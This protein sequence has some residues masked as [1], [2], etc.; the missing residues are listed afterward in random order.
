MTHPKLRPGQVAPDATL[1]NLE[2][3]AVNLSEAWKTSPALLVFLR[4]LG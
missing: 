3:R 1:V 4:H 2:G